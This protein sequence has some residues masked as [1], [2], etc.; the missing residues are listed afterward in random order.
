MQKRDPFL[1]GAD[2]G[3][4]VDGRYLFGSVRPSRAP[5]DAIITCGQEDAAKSPAAASHIRRAEPGGR[6]SFVAG[7]LLT[8]RRHAERGGETLARIE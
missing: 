4:F 2:A 3:G 5:L 1:L 8:T 6:S 7:G